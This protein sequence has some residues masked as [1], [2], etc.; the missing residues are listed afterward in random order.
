GNNSASV[1]ETPQQADLSLSKTVSDSSPNV[2][3][4][5]T[6][7]LTLSN[8]GPW[9]ASNVTVQ[10][11]LPAGLTYHSST[12]SQ[13]SYNSTTGVWSVGTVPT[14]TPQ[15]LTIQARVVSAAARTNTAVVNHSDQFDPDSTDNTGSATETPQ[16]ADLAVS[17][18]VSSARP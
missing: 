12:P 15:T 2:G 13:G 7:T 3:D 10:D 5:V 16:Q 18:T 4:T 14:A 8:Q 17:K 9:A 1:T 6:F 11:L